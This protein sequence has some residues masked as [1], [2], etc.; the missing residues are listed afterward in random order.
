M[1]FDYLSH[2]QLRRI[3]SRVTEKL[4]TS[5]LNLKDRLSLVKFV[6]RDH[7]E[8]FIQKHVDE[9]T[10]AAFK[11]LFEGT[12]LVFYLE[13]A[14]CRFT[15]PGQMTVR[16]GKPLTHDNGDL[17]EKSLFDFVSEE[18]MNSL[19][20]AVALCLDRDENVLYWYRNL[21]GEDSFGIQGYRRHRL[22][23]DF[24][25]HGR[26]DRQPNHLVWV[27]ESKGNQLEGNA[28]TEYKRD[29]ARLFSEVG[30]QVSWQQLGDEFKDHQFCFHVLDEAQEEGRDWKDEL[31][32][33]LSE[34][35]CRG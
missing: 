12:R 32:T 28:D 18:E 10:E 35:D 4:I 16:A 23:P 3:V 24:V 1:A 8:R 9:Q 22:R 13:C 15:I 29:V 17:T 21:V 19:E 5:E 14:E 25:A 33:I 7:V 30:R 34:A 6:V 2:K 11:K 20:R 31:Q 27:V 26:V